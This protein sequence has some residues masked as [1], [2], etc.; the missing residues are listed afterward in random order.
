MTSPIAHGV[1]TT[2][3]MD[4]GHTWFITGTQS[5][6]MTLWDL[7]F[8][9]KMRSWRV[10]AGSGVSATLGSSS[11]GIGTTAI[12]RVVL[13]PTSNKRTRVMVAIAPTS[14]EPSSSSTSASPSH[15]PSSPLLDSAA[16]QTII[17]VWDIAR[18][19][20]VESFVVDESG[21]KLIGPGGQGGFSAD[22]MQLV[23]GGP[24]NGESLGTSAADAIAALYVL[25]ELLRRR[26][27][28]A[29]HLLS[30]MQT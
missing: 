6:M 10:G 4:R 7:R 23:S 5:G 14:V 2:S 20:L 9:L 28:I 13:H 3:C 29:L 26:P 27:Q 16:A 12:H 24:T 8:G 11:A 18:V 1:I 21:G 22:Q 30:S 19:V 17:E 25:E 15:S